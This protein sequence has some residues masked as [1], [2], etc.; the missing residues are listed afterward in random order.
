MST[1]QTIKEQVIR[2]IGNRD[3]DSTLASIMMNTNMVIEWL[4]T[5]HHW[6]ELEAVATPSMVVGQNQ[7]TKAQLNLT[8]LR[9]FKIYSLQLYDG[10]NW[11]DPMA[12]VPPNVFDKKVKAY[13]NLTTG[14]PTI[15]S[16]FGGTFTFNPTPDATYLL[17]IK[18]LK[19]PT[20]VN[21]D[22]ST[23]PYEDL[24]SGIVS[25]VSGY[26]W[27]GLGEKTQADYWFKMAGDILGA[28]E[29]DTRALIGQQASSRISTN[30]SA[31]W[32]DPFVRG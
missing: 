30:P 4:A 18:Y 29:I 25:M 12:F 14:V 16:L 31:P 2:N 17:D 28:F 13:G 15:F 6:P 8:D 20:L 11:R 7:Y 1:Y 5:Q 21:Q 3:D 23:I 32:A 24:D 27:L 19:R 10:S 26:T 22:S 9:A